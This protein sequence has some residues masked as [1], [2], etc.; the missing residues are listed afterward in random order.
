MEH[1]ETEEMHEVVDQMLRSALI[2]VG[3]VQQRLARRRQ[4]AAD[5]ARMVA[6]ASRTE[7]D[8]YAAA[9]DTMLRQSLRPATDPRWF[10]TSTPA[11]RVA[12]RDMADRFAEVSPYA[13]TVLDHIDSEAARRGQTLTP[14]ETGGVEPT[15]TA[16]APDLTKPSPAT[17]TQ[18]PTPASGTDP[19]SSRRRPIAVD[20]AATEQEVADRLAASRSFP[21]PLWDKMRRESGMKLRPGSPTTV[22]RSR[23]KDLGL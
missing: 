6:A 11:E 12:T 16:D 22:P 2:A 13:K 3:S 17:Q 5:Q 4:V 9:Q 19:G 21:R 1:R 18:T 10:D 20:T 8:A 23:D 14:P 15:P 7:T